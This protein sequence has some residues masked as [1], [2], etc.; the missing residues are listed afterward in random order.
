MDDGKVQVILVLSFQ[1][2]AIYLRGTGKLEEQR[3]ERGE[4]KVEKER[5]D[6]IVC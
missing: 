3:F 1:G 2:S 6:E 5:G 4:S